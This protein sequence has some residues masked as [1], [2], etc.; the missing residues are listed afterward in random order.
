MVTLQNV[1]LSP[2]SDSFIGQ[3]VLIFI[4][5][6]LFLFL[7][8][9]KWRSNGFATGAMQANEWRKAFGKHMAMQHVGS[10]ISLFHPLSP[11]LVLS[12][13]LRLTHMSRHTHFYL[14]LSHRHSNTHIK[15]QNTLLSVL[16]LLFLFVQIISVSSS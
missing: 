7:L 15:S 3:N 13:T 5:I 11:S 8:S 1:F 9:A 12:L 16:S 6:F 2:V 14:F 4:W 10:S